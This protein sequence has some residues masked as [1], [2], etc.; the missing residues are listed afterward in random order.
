MGFEI[1]ETKMMKRAVFN[2]VG[3]VMGNENLDMSPNTDRLERTDAS[4][5]NEDEYA[6]LVRQREESQK[7]MED[8]QARRRYARA[9]MREAI[10]SKY[11]IE[12]GENDKS[13]IKEESTRIKQPP[14]VPTDSSMGGMISY[15][16]ESA[17][18]SIQNFFQD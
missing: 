11:K 13:I 18:Y 16:R 2:A 3:K 10:R 5:M 7:I 8:K 12:N 4:T 15:V 14:R 6:E 1:A 17:Q 9:T